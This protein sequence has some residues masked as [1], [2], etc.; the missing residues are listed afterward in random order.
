MHAPQCP[1]PLDPPGGNELVLDIAPNIA[2]GRPGGS[3]AEPHARGFVTAGD[4][5]ANGLG[6]ATGETRC[7]HGRT[8]SPA[9]GR[10]TAAGHD[11]VMDVQTLTGSPRNERGAGQVSYLL[12]A[13]GQ[14]GSQHLCITWV[15]CQPGSQQ[16]RHQHMTQE[17][18]Y[19]VV[20]GRGQMLLGDEEREVGE[21]TMVF[22]PPGTEHAIRNTSSGLLIYVSAT[23]PPFAASIAGQRWQP[24]DLTS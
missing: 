18:V 21:G 23:S 8:G 11:A 2:R 24:G 17:Q 9:S 22:V 13:E 14:F 4:L 20:R 5:L 10:R 16:A 6:A 12:L 19:V 15:E 7:R 1:A 3:G